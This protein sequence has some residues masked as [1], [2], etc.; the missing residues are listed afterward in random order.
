MFICAIYRAVYKTSSERE[1]L[2]R[3]FESLYVD[4]LIFRDTNVD[5]LNL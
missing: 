4:T 1:T 3:L 5:D 2:E